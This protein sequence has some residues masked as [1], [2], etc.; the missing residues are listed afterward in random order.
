MKKLFFVVSCLISFL[1]F[2]QKEKT[3]ASTQI[4]SLTNIVRLNYMPVEMPKGISNAT[5]E[6]MG[7]AGIH[8]QIPIT[9]NIYG[10]AN[11]H[12]ALFGDQGGLFTLGIE[13]GYT[14]K[15]FSNFFIDTNLNFGGGGGY[16][17]V[18]NKGAYINPN[19]GF[20]YHF[21]KFHIGVQYSHFNFYTGAIKSN[22]ASIFAEIPIQVNFSN[23]QNANQNF[24]PTKSNPWYRPFHKNAFGLRFDQFL[25]IG[26][27]RKDGLNNFELLDNTL[28]LLG[29]EYQRYFRKNAF[30]FIHTDAIYKGLRAGFMD[31]F[32]GIGYE[33]IQTK[34]FNVFTKFAFGAAGGR[35]KE[36]GGATIY[37]SL[38]LEYKITPHISL[39]GH[40]GYLR[41]IDGDFEAYTFGGGLKINTNT[42][43]FYA[44]YT[45]IRAKSLKSNGIRIGI[46]H[47]T[48]FNL[49]RDAIDNFDPIDLHLLSLHLNYDINKYL[50]ITGQAAFAY[51]STYN[52]NDVKSKLGAGGYADGM[53]GLGFYSPIFAKEKLQLFTEFLIGAGGGAGIDT[54][55]GI[56]SK[57]KLGG[58]YCINDKLSIMASAGKVFSPLG[59]GINSNNVNVGLSIDF[60]SIKSIFKINKKNMN[61]GLYAKFNTSKGEILVNLEFEKTPGTVGNFVALAEGNMENSAKPQGTPYYDGLKFHRVITD[62]M[63]QGGCPQGTGTGNPGYS[64]DDEIVAE[65]KHDTPGVLSMANSGPSSNG[66]QFFITHTATPWLDGKHTVFGKVVTGQDI[67]D[68]IAQGDELESLEIVRVGE[69]AE[70]FNAIEA[71]RTFEGAREAK[72]KAEAESRELELEKLAAGYEKTASGL[73]Y[74]I[75][76]AGN[77]GKKA[78]KGQQVSVHYKGQLADGTVFDSSYKRNEPI[79]FAIGVGQVISGW[80]EGIQLLE[81][82]DKARLV[83]PSNLGYGA[84]GAGGVIPP[85]ATLVFDVE[86][87]NVK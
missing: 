11:M 65:L 48:Y 56:I 10:G 45:D 31:V 41:A 42:G 37:P 5:G 76:Q 80:D 39:Q 62:F 12:T 21:P 51:E 38:G 23:Y 22:S 47:Q 68:A 79:E 82:G 58:Y 27:S 64:F 30:A 34:H 1:T 67:V 50:Y 32:G 54:K 6:T 26:N 71:F 49:Q 8:Y 59:N 3:D 72:I 7:L 19:I 55:E 69:A 74:K 75:I 28:Y 18:I 84:S 61:N 78:T 77:S 35:I 83:I 63:I 24:R 9:K 36:E 60:S 73:R 43:G 70:K 33:P 46:Q 66:S 85:H 81:V 14:Q 57:A 20:S 86:L 15:L 16:R 87:V 52:G 13:L 53:V 25:P 2:S 44:P 17:A 40:G 4:T 29:F